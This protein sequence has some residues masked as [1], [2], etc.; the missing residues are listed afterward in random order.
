MR[1]TLRE[2]IEANKRGS[3]LLVCGMVLLITVLS[4]T[5]VGIWHP[6]N[7]P[8]GAAS[9]LCLAL[10]CSFISRVWGSKI[11]L[12]ISG[13]REA[14]QHEDQVLRNVVEE[15]AIASGLPMPKIYVIDDY[16][17][18]AFAT[19]RDPQ[20]G[21][22]CVTTG[23]LAKLNRD[24]LQGVMAHELSHIRNYDIRYMTTVSTMAGL[25]VLLA[26][27]V[28]GQL[29]WGFW[30]RSRSSD[31]NNGGNNPLGIIFLVLGL[32]LAFTAPM[33]GWLLEMA[34]SRQREYLAD[35]SAAEMTRYPE[36]LASALQKISEDTD[37]LEAGN[38]ATQH[39]YIVNPL[40][41]M[42][43]HQDLLSTHPSTESRIKALLGD[44]EYY[45]K[46]R[47]FGFKV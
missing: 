18:N 30:G 17:P 3:F 43:E 46:E 33:M 19:G 29:R 34:V 35:A 22:V 12:G 32:I 26:D 23:L 37:M 5:I 13:S 39:M 15:M 44:A 11:V 27:V 47:K 36:G 40:K 10:L 25:I 41:L 31:D 7:W 6:R 28:Q 14:T 38:R 20:N 1:K 4:A 45:A 2:Q 24:E 16:A 21:I 42:E 9:G 8:I